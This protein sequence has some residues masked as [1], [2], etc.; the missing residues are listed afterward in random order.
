M[1]MLEDDKEEII[2]EVCIFVIYKKNIHREVAH[3]LSLWFG[4][5]L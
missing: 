3:A 1:C 4:T 5:C 2:A